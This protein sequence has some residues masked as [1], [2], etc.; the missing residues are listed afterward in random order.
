MLST[1]LLKKTGIVSYG[2]Y[3]PRYRIKVSDIAAAWGKNAQSI[4][5]GLGLQEKSVPSIDEDVATISVE[6][7]R[8]ALIKSSIAPQDIG[9]IYIGSESHPYAVKPTGTIVAEAIGATP[10]SMVAD[11]EFACKAGT[12]AIQICMGLVK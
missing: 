10:N 8:A 3:I 9:A 12:A 2:A 11:Y 6:A 4:Q 5:S 7:A 1:A